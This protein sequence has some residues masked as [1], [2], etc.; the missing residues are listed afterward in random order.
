VTGG[1]SGPGVGAQEGAAETGDALH[2][3]G[4]ALDTLTDGFAIYDSADR[5]VRANAAYAAVFGRAR[6][7]IV[8]G[9]SYARMVELCFETGLIAP[10]S[11]TPGA[12]LARWH[13]G[14]TEPLVLRLVS[15][16]YVRMIDRA[17]PCGD[18]VSL[19][20]NITGEMR[21]WAAVEAIPDG[22][23]LYDRDDRLVICNRRYHEIYP[24]ASP[25]MEPG[26]RFEDILRFGVARG[27]FADAVGREE[28]WLA[29]RMERHRVADAVLEQR[30]ED[31][32]WLRVLEKPTPDGGRVGLRVDI[33]H[34]KAQQEAL[35][36]ANERLRAALAERDA[37]ERRFQD[38]AAITTDWFWEQD[39][40]LRFTYF[41][42]GYARVTGGDPAQHVG[43][44]RAEL[45]QDHP[46]AR[47]SADWAGLERR[48]A[49]RE[50][51]SDFVYRG[52]S[53]AENPIWVRISGAPYFD[54]DGRFAG[55][56]G[57]GSDVSPLYDAIRRAEA[58]NEA[59]SAFLANMSHEIRTPMNGV[60]GMADLLSETAL[61]EEQ[62]LFVDTIRSSAEA[63]LVIINDV[64]DYSKIEA[65]R[66]EIF[67]EPFDLE[68]LIHEVM[69]LMQPRVGARR[70]ELL[71]DYDIFLPTRFVGDGG[72]LRQ[73]L[74]NLVG[75]AVKFT[76]SG[77]ILVRVTGIEREGAGVEVHVA[78][79]D[80]GVGIAAGDLEHVFA[81][82]SQ[83]ESGTARR[84]EGT[85]LGLAITRRLIEL[86]GGRVWAESELG[87][88]SC[89]GFAVTLPA[90]E[91][92]LAGLGARGD[93]PR[94]VLVVD[95][96]ALN[97][98]ILNRQ[99]SALGLE[100]A[101]AESA[102]VA[103]ER[104]S[105]PGAAA[106]D[107]VLTDHRMPGM[108]GVAL[109]RE[110]HARAIAVPVILLSSHQTLAREAQ[111]EGLFAAVLKKP[112]LR[113]DLLRAIAGQEVGAAA[114]AG[115]C[116]P[117]R[118]LHRRLRVLAAE[119]NAT[120]R[121]VL[122]RM[123]ADLPVDLR[124]ARDGAE[125]VDSYRAAPPDLVLM[126]ISMPRVDGIDATGQIRAFEAA[127]GLPRVP[128]IALTAHAMA[129]DAAR[130]LAAGMDR[131]LTKP[132]RRA[133]LVEVMNALTGVPP[134]DE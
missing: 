110:M 80:S 37:A 61:D 74:L 57:V 13:E 55:Y 42:Q 29:E 84:F 18:R 121:L 122:R 25:A 5:L 113:G 76:E 1:G 130:F 53:R 59:K 50:A 51:F 92:G 132:L 79:E 124:L 90:A 91:P 22:F 7:E 100:V 64:L 15:G 23:V 111:G 72:R 88:G 26:A 115:R 48:L 38:I 30:L 31:G 16:E 133:A 41:S 43:R 3:L 102:P 104:L 120:N 129:G 101:L 56:R 109:A 60:V 85:G 39:A 45:L 116:P 103:L 28:A 96:L 70:I 34:Q 89:F 75:N 93:G 73:V 58:A 17:M 46:D 19:V 54:T 77:F 68:R 10:G 106:V 123:L 71:F 12:M 2:R 44:T 134:G 9:L 4:A 117:D 98:T 33:T 83:A 128:V 108:D 126:D 99:L 67:P 125:A 62:R 63:L 94:R 20:V 105:D 35:E 97:R 81:E 69:L 32:R 6:G 78:V 112:A 8:P 36:A 65:G 49:A 24:W 131:Y 40:D 86:M 127:A 114:V 119:D 87:R 14:A 52:F 47:A 118:R 107:L 82:F 11:L 27:Q 21:M 66:L 95:D